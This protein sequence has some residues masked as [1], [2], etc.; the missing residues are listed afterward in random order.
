MIR[1]LTLA[2]ALILAAPGA[3]GSA[4]A[5]FPW[6][7]D[8]LQRPVEEMAAVA[9]VG[10]PGG[11]AGYAVAITDWDGD[12]HRDL[13]VAEPW[14]DVED[15]DGG[16]RYGAGRIG[17]FLA[18]FIWR[19]DGGALWTPRQLSMEDA[20]VLIRGPAGAR[21]GYRLLASPAGEAGPALAASLPDL[22]GARDP[23]GLGDRPAAL[24]AGEIW[25]LDGADGQR[26]EVDAEDVLWNRGKLWWEGDAVDGAAWVPN[27]VGYELA[28]L[29]DLD[30]DAIPELAVSVPSVVTYTGEPP[31]EVRPGGTLIVPGQ[32]ILDGDLG[33]VGHGW[34]LAGSVGQVDPVFT[35]GAYLPRLAS[36]GADGFVVGE[37]AHHRGA[38]AAYVVPASA[39]HAPAAALDAG[40]Q[41]WF[42]A[43]GPDPVVP[44]DGGLLT[45][46]GEGTDVGGEF[47]FGSALAPLHGAPYLAVAALQYTGPESAPRAVTELIPRGG[48]AA[49]ASPLMETDDLDP[50]RILGDE[51]PSPAWGDEVA[52]EAELDAVARHIEN[53][54]GWWSF[55]L[56]VCLFLSPEH[57]DHGCQ[58]DYAGLFQFASVAMAPYP[59]SAHVPAPFDGGLV[60]G[61]PLFDGGRGAVHALLPDWDSPPEGDVELAPMSTPP[62]GWRVTR[63]DGEVDAWL[64]H[65]VLAPGDVDG[66]GVEDLVIG[67]PGLP[68]GLEG[69]APPRGA[70][71]LLL[72]GFHAD[73]DGDGLGPS[74]GD[75]D[76]GDPDTFPGANERCDGVDN[77][78][79]GEVPANE[80]DDDGDGYMQCAG[81]CDDTIPLL[82]PA[83]MDDDGWSPCGG[84]CDDGDPALNPD[85]GDGDGYSTCDGDCDDGD[86]ALEPA[87]R[88]GDGWTTCGGASSSPDCDDGDPEVNPGA[89]EIADGRDNDCDGIVDEGV[90]SCLGCGWND[91]GRTASRRAAP[92]TLILALAALVSLRLRRSPAGRTPG[93]R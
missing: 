37:L 54:S 44:L 48:L 43:P 67:A 17:V 49:G 32:R 11:R 16:V 73:H 59:R 79:D 88:D 92:S 30:G 75:C 71:Y 35:G 89:D 36:H 81:D 65:T 51:H 39:L 7:G 56:A 74:H 21:L 2:S 38:G 26:G 87:D 20:D 91:A 42:E 18:P 23:W 8:D 47:A 70:A 29:D 33:D 86:P 13:V 31:V 76:D 4:T 22:T 45:V 90:P 57:L 50:W 72:S 10:E 80:R 63:L 28:A 34:F 41:G 60:I 12:G 1:R 27:D 14:A 68:R 24:H 46:V 9:L 85:D 62:P 61:E 93:S 52:L 40:A 82:H 15:P 55:L 83:D 6:T 78:C 3:S 66:D 64:G 19:A 53:S 69:A 25:L 77:D 58:A 84:D 5:P